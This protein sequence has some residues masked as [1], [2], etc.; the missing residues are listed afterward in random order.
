MAFAPPK[1]GS[2]SEEALK[3]ME[4]QLERPALH[5]NVELKPGVVV[6]VDN[7]NVAHTRSAYANGRRRYVGAHFPEAHLE[8]RLKETKFIEVLHILVSPGEKLGITTGLDL[9]V[10]RVVPGGT[11]DAAQIRVGD[12]VQEVDGTPVSR[13][14]NSAAL[15]EALF[16]SDSPAEHTVRVMRAPDA[17]GPPRGRD[18]Q[19][20]A[21][22]G[23]R[24]ARVHVQGLP[25]RRR[26]DLRRG[27]RTGGAEVDALRHEG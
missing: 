20:A 26:Q 17:H 6:L 2:A 25:P 23:A 14:E 21:Q 16:S 5:V 10:L 22:E 7:W 3:K 18:A 8:Q 1:S 13:L 19:H 11:A 12:K 24:H 9:E 4:A 15:R 27:P